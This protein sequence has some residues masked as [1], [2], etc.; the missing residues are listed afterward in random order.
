MRGVLCC[1]STMS[2]LVKDWFDVYTASW[3][4]TT[5]LRVRKTKVMLSVKEKVNYSALALQYSINWS[6]IWIV[7]RRK[8]WIS[9]SSRNI[10]DTELV[11]CRRAR[12][13][14]TPSLLDTQKS[15]YKTVSQFP[16]KANVLVHWQRAAG[17]AVWRVPAPCWTVCWLCSLRLLVL[18]GLFY[19]LVISVVNV[20]LQKHKRPVMELGSAQAAV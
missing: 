4:T 11:W 3:S 14:H 15:F 19:R 10:S 2:A 5:I 20:I 16:L 9:C 6:S 7:N 8:T 1:W 12:Y 13:N 18:N 17:L